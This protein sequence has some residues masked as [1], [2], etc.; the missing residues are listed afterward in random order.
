MARPVDIMAETVVRNHR[1]DR[2]EQA[3]GSGDQRFG[4]AGRDSSQRRL[5]DI[6]Q[7]AERVHDAPDRPEQADIRRHRA[8]RRQE[9]QVHVER[10]EFALECGAHGAAGAVEHGTHVERIARCLLALDEF[11]HARFENAGQC[12]VLVTLAGRALV[13]CVQVAA[14]P[15]AALE[16]FGLAAGRTDREHL[17]EDVGPAGQR[18]DQQQ[19]HDQLHDQVRIGDQGEKRKVLGYVHRWAIRRL[20]NLHAF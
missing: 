4:D 16:L 12:A 6:G 14:G 19:C 15:E 11:A 8:D 3:D 5:L 20:F 1:R 10:V 18:H 7:A 9:V 17:A 13:Q 2:G